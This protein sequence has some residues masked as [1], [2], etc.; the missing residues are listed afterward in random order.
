[1]SVKYNQFGCLFARK[2]CH[3]YVNLDENHSEYISQLEYSSV[4][5]DSMYLINCTSPYIA[6]AVGKLSK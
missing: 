6:F 4:L 3:P 5:G 2:P 1:M